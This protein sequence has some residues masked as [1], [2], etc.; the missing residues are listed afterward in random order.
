MKKHF[1]W[2]LF[3]FSTCGLAH[4][5][6]GSENRPQAQNYPCAVRSI[7]GQTPADDSI[8][9]AAGYKDVLVSISRDGYIED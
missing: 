4:A 2:I 1:M 8:L 6:P 9:I 7:I 3:W 5:Q